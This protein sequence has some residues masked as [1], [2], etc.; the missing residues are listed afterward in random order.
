MYAEAI[1]KIAVFAHLLVRRMCPKKRVF[2][3]HLTRQ[4]PPKRQVGIG[5]NRETQLMEPGIFFTIHLTK[6]GSSDDTGVEAL[7]LCLAQQGKNGNEY[8][9]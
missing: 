4:I 5:A 6:S 3:F 9:K 8:N 2:Q 1:R 7:G